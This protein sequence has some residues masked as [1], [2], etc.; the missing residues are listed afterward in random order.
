MDIRYRLLDSIIAA[1]LRHMAPKVW[2][3][4]GSGNGLL[5]GDIKSWIDPMLTYH[6]LH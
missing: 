6:C 2:F 1:E 5:P 4:I 3:N